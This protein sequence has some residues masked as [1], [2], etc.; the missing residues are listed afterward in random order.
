[1]TISKGRTTGDRRTRE[2]SE[3]IPHKAIVAVGRETFRSLARYRN[4]A[5]DEAATVLSDTLSTTFPSED[6]SENEARFITVG[7][8]AN[9][10]IL[11]VVH[12]ED[13]RVIRI[14]SARQSTAQE[15]RYYEK[16]KPN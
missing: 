4:I 8:S 14:I 3:S 1:M 5:F 11:V 12:T 9:L 2:T 7:L 10:R 13:D 15:R 6:H 16:R